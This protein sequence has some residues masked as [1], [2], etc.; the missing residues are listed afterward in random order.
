[1]NFC[2]CM[3]VCVRACM[4]ECMHACRALNASAFSDT[5]CKVV[6]SDNLSSSKSHISEVQDLLGLPLFSYFL[7]NSFFLTESIVVMVIIDSVVGQQLAPPFVV[8]WSIIEK[9]RQLKSKRLNCHAVKFTQKLS[10]LLILS[11]F[12]VFLSHFIDHFYNI[13]RSSLKCFI[14]RLLSNKDAASFICVP[15]T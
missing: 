15:F 11:H 9:R 13:F 3:C 5:Q 6:Y 4:H 7:F 14:L 8:K 1:M 10:F 2:V 12:N